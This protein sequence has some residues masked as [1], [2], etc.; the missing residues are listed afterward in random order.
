M[1]EDNK[2]YAFQLMSGYPDGFIDDIRKLTITYTTVVFQFRKNNLFILNDDKLLKNY[3]FG[4]FN[5]DYYYYCNYDVNFN[6]DINEVYQI[7]KNANGETTLQIHMENK[8]D[9]M[10]I[11]N[12]KKFRN[13]IKK[14]IIYNKLYDYKQIQDKMWKENGIGQGLSEYFGHPDKLNFSKKL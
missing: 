14:H 13:K 5:M 8:N 11:I 4:D 10:I 1:I 7:I 3:L 9:N 2:N 12:I 6:I